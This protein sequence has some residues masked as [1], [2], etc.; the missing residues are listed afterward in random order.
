MFLLSSQFLAAHLCG[1]EPGSSRRSFHQAAQ[2]LANPME[3]RGLIKIVARSAL[4]AL[5]S[6]LREIVIGEHDDGRRGWVTLQAFGD[7][8]AASVGHANI[9]D[10]DVG[11]GPTDLQ[12]AVRNTVRVT[13]NLQSGHICKAGPQASSQNLR[14]I[15]DQ[16]FHG[17][18]RT[19]SYALRAAD[20]IG[21][22]GIIVWP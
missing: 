11:F 9:Q 15:N 7:L 6:K 8:D 5:P 22:N 16:N 19:Q 2:Y 17:Q 20:A 13:D 12:D 21:K 18:P 1:I 3:L 14:V 10:Y 4:Q